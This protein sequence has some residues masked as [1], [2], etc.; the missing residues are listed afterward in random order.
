MS[1]IMYCISVTNFSVLCSDMH[2][3]LMNLLISEC[4]YREEF[5]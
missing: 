5:K 3:I 2:V 4:I 1:I